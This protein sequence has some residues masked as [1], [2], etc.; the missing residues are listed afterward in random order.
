MRGDHN[1]K[2]PARLEMPEAW[3]ERDQSTAPEPIVPAA[4]VGH[5]VESSGNSLSLGTPSNDLDET[6]LGGLFE[7][8]RDAVDDLHEFGNLDNQC[9]MLSKGVER[10]LKRLP[11]TI[12][13][14]DQV[15]FGTSVQALSLQFKHER[16][17]LEEVAPEKLGHLEATLMRANLIAA[18]LP[19]WLAF[20]KQEE[21]TEPVFAARQDDIEAIFEHAAEALESDPEHFDPSLFE[22]IR[23]YL[24]D[25][26]MVSYLASKDLLVGIAHKTFVLARDLAKDTVSEARKMT[27]KGIAGA[28]LAHLAGPLLK[29]AG[30]LPN[31]LAWLAQWIEYLPKIL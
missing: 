6:A 2:L 9:P 11:E 18:N 7:D 20:K 31:E 10:F 22:R 30:I 26:T 19:L 27:I 15:R 1:T 29:L 28:L 23:E 21:E 4:P 25:A 3:K 12:E 8:L 16:P 13:Q 17:V 14:L 24:D 5:A